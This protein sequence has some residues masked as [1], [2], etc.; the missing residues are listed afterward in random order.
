MAKEDK[1]QPRGEEE[2]VRKG[3]LARHQRRYEQFRVSPGQGSR[4][5]LLD[6]AR[7]MMLVFSNPFLQ[8]TDKFIV[9]VR[10]KRNFRESRG[11]LNLF[12]SR[13]RGMEFYSLDKYLVPRKS[14]GFIV[15]FLW[16][17]YGGG[18]LGFT[19]EGIKPLRIFQ[20]G[21]F[22]FVERSIPRFIDDSGG[23]FEVLTAQSR[24]TCSAN[25]TWRVLWRARERKVSSVS[26][27]ARPEVI[28]I[29]DQIYPMSIPNS[30]NLPSFPRPAKEF[31]FPPPEKEKKKGGR[32]FSRGISR[33][34]TRRF[35]DKITKNNSRVSGISIA[36]RHPRFHGNRSERKREGINDDTTTAAILGEAT[37]PRTCKSARVSE[38]R[39]GGCVS[40]EQRDRI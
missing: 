24:C 23:S 27:V 31:A 28:D 8:P 22:G 40:R 20:A 26:S 17:S 29:I 9:V 36:G 32:V 7:E 13:K 11:L 6:Y 30:P 18:Q 33:V 16:T 37:R 39:H 2:G 25:K 1:T 38:R 21:E 19:V 5:W 4:F 12:S 10:T 15:R 34:G 35:R 14:H 3:E